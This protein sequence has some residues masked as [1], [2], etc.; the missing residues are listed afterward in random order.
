MPLLMLLPFMLTT[1][2]WCHSTCLGSF[3]LGASGSV[4]TKVYNYLDQR[5]SHVMLVGRFL[6]GWVSALCPVRRPPPAVFDLQRVLR[7]LIHFLQAQRPGPLAEV[8][9]PMRPSRSDSRESGLRTAIS[10]FLL[11]LPPSSTWSLLQNYL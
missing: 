5:P 6:P 4:K 9:H 3:L 11:L 10:S 1:R 7:P 8:R 2:K